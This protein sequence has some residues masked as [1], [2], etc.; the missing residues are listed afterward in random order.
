ME[1]P[2]VGHRGC[3]GRRIRPRPESVCVSRPAV[4]AAVIA[5]AAQG[6]NGQV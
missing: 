3:A 4:V 5:Q 1:N 2:L 6:L